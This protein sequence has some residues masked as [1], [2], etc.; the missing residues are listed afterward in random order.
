M[1]S[2][3]YFTNLNFV[4]IFLLSLGIYFL[5]IWGSN[6]TGFSST[7]YSMVVIFQT[8]QYY[9]TVFLCVFLCYLVDM[10]IESYY[11]EIK[12][13]PVDY[14]RRVINRKLPF[15][16]NDKEFE[17]IYM[18][19][20]RE[21]LAIDLKREQQC[22]RRREKKLLKMRAKGETTKGKEEQPELKIFTSKDLDKP[23]EKVVEKR[24]ENGSGKC[25][26]EKESHIRKHENERQ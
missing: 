2:E 22:E 15:E 16:E 6:Y 25:H 9:L 10:F 11:F 19:V 14:L 1:V 7:Y 17:R 26:D 3:M 12:T 21:G 5:Y 13:S 4:C 24:S 20:R 18:G 23:T 8:P